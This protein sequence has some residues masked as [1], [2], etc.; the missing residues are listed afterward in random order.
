MEVVVSSELPREGREGRGERGEE[1]RA[2]E[3]GGRR[4]R[5]GR[6]DKRKRERKLIRRLH[7]R[8]FSHLEL[9]IC[10]RLY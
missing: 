6:G 4:E 8:Q 10:C 1:E 3:R 2:K 5:G 9:L 7:H